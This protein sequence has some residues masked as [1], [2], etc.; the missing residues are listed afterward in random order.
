MKF[1]RA[2]R[3][4]AVEAAKRMIR[5]FELKKEIFGVEKLVRDITL[6]D[7]SDDDMDTLKC[8]C[9]QLCPRTDM[10]GR[11]ILICFNGIR[12]YEAPENAV[13]FAGYLLS[14]LP[15]M[16]ASPSLFLYSPTQR[17]FDSSSLQRRATFYVLMSMMESTEAQI[18]GIAA[19]YYC[20][21]SV[22]TKSVN[23][24]LRN[25]LPVHFACFHLCNN[26]EDEFRLTCGAVRALD[27]K[28]RVRYRSHF[29]KFASIVYSDQ[30][31]I[32]Y[33]QEKSLTL[34]RFHPTRFAFRMSG[35]TLLVRDS[36]Y[37]A[38]RE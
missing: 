15:I 37:R 2:E 19:I 25:S 12:R 35:K 6:Q 5:F 34:P 4:D 38:S 20:L 7:L 21:D 14:H 32:H 18:S 22:N 23:E 16:R 11:P 26:D 24:G 36:E 27:T 3:Y 28:N 13:S 29:G 31:V 9:V 17:A 33:D 10:A 1:L 30:L 8:G